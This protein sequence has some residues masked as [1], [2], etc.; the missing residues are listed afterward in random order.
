[1]SP[2]ETVR[3]LEALLFAANAPLSA[4]DL[5]LRLPPETDIGKALSTL[6]AE[7]AGRGVRLE[8]LD[9]RWQ[10]RT[11][12]D[13]GW[14]MVEERDV[15]RKLSRAALETLA[16][17]AYHQPITRAE[18]E[19]VRGVGLSKG[20]LDVLLEMNLIR[21]KGRRRAPGR[22]VTSGTSAF[23]LE[24]FSLPSLAD[25]PGMAEMKAAGLLDLS[26]PA[27]FVLPDP[28]AAITADEA[29]GPIDDETVEFHQDFYE[30][31]LDGL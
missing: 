29:L 11:A 26:V 8:C 28:S 13:L 5:A 22:P 6:K 9:D 24:Q 12:P 10:F 23:F 19:S 1:M 16:I 18:I 21:L 31:E 4:H 3:A 2:E 25:M 14:L 30:A 7:Y 27:D 17:I 20:T 15:P